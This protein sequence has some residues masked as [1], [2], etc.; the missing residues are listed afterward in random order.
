MRSWSAI[1][2]SIQVMMLVEKVVKFVLRW[3]SLIA[4]PD[5]TFRKGRSQSVWHFSVKCRYWPTQ[6]YEEITGFG[7]QFGICPLCT[8]L[9]NRENPK[10]SGR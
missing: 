3:L 10:L 2:E 5:Q 1:A 8:E 6:D 4:T 7:P 9:W